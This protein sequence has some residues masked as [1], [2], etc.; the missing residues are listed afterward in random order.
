MNDEEKLPIISTRGRPLREYVSM[1]ARPQ[2]GC[3][4]ASFVIGVFTF[5]W[6]AVLLGMPTRAM[7]DPNYS[8]SFMFS[9]LWNVSLIF[10]AILSML[11]FSLG[12]A[13]A[14]QS[15]RRHSLTWLGVVLNF[16][17]AAFVVFSMLSG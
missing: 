7:L 17:P 16:F 11:G 1:L 13:G 14:C 5:L 6:F 15:N 4:I 12:L 10:L 8:S 2:S 9:G 3:G